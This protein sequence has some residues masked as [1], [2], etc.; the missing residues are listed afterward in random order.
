MFLWIFSCFWFDNYF[1]DRF[2][3]KELVTMRQT[4]YTAVSNWP[5]WIHI[6]SR[7]DGDNFRTICEGYQSSQPTSCIRQL[8]YFLEFFMNYFECATITDRF[9]LLTICEHKYL[10]LSYQIFSCESNY[11]CSSN[12]LWLQRKCTF[13]PNHHDHICSMKMLLTPHSQ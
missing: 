12:D 10:L 11:T 3:L 4:I 1:K 9:F 13:I 2:V 8:W 6:Y 5:S 7:Y